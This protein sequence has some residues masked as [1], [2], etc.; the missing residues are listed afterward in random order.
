MPGA[1]MADLFSTGHVVDL[2]FLLMV[3]EGM[4]VTAYRGKTGRGVAPVD[5][6]SNLLSGVFLLLAL[7]FALLN[8]DWPMIALALIAA[9]AAHLAD[10]WRRWLR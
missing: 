6:I 4:I 3:A 1:V 2:I 5:L 8:V 9:F 7:R 10:L